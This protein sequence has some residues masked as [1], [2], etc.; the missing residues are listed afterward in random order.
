MAFLSQER[1]NDITEAKKQ[2]NAGR[3]AHMPY[4]RVTTLTEL[5]EAEAGVEARLRG[6]IVP[7]ILRR[8]L[9]RTGEAKHGKYQ[10]SQPI[11]YLLCSR[12]QKI[13]AVLL[14]TWS[15]YFVGL[16]WILLI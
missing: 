15:D 1:S 3:I 12:L 10:T 2:Q 9:E 8:N 7:A 6:W 16:E 4:C 5:N 14:V 13:A 11:R